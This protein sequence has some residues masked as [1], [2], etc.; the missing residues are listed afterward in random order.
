MSNVL[1]TDSNCRETL[2]RIDAYV[3]NQIDTAG[4]AAIAAH[5]ETCPSCREE[6]ELRHRLRG[7]LKQ[8]VDSSPARGISNGT[9]ASD[10]VRLA[11]T[12]R[13]WMVGTGTR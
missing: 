12:I 1:M 10:R 6:L 4:G 8:A 3:D 9:R 7:R 11:R 2:R 5:V 13:C